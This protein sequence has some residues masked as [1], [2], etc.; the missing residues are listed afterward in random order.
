MDT[1]RCNR[2][3]HAVLKVNILLCFVHEK[4]YGLVENSALDLLSLQSHFLAA[5]VRQLWQAAQEDV[6]VTAMLHTEE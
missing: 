6:A 5:S 3:T 1:E 2:N 4:I